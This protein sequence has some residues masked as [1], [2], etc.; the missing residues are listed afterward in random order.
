[1]LYKQRKTNPVSIFGR[2]P[3][4]NLE[5]VFESSKAKK[6]LRSFDGV[7][8]RKIGPPA[9]KRPHKGGNSNRSVP[10][11]KLPTPSSSANSVKFD[12]RLPNTGRELDDIEESSAPPSPVDAV[13]STP[14]PYPGC[15]TKRRRGT[16]GRSVD[17]PSKRH[18]GA[19]NEAK[20][21]QFA[22]TCFQGLTKHLQELADS[23][24]GSSGED[25][26]SRAA[27]NAND[28]TS[29]DCAGEAGHDHRS[30]KGNGTVIRHSSLRKDGDWMDRSDGMILQ[31]AHSHIS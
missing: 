4:I 7:A 15:G 27:D 10:P 21:Q 26:A 12:D 11:H 23:V 9:V 6:P 13:P 18:Q 31:V 5:E 17:S 25:I 16:R 24:K 22:T 1:M 30:G 28:A 20:S 14:T 29:C 19:N 3:E 8:S 2:C